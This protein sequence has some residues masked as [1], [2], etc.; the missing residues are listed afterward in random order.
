VY[1][2]VCVIILLT[3]YLVFLPVECPAQ[4]L[5]GAP[6][7]QAILAA[8]NQIQANRDAAIKYS[9]EEA[10]MRNLEAGL[11]KQK[12]KQRQQG[13]GNSLSKLPSRIHPYFSHILGFDDN[14][15]ARKD[16]NKTALTN[17]ITPGFKLNLQQRRHNVAM[18]GHVDALYYNKRKGS[19]V[20]NGQYDIMTNFNIDRFIF[21][22]S[23]SLFSNYISSDKLGV[24][25][26]LVDNYISNDT[27]FVLVSNFNRTGFDLSYRRKFFQYE[28]IKK[29]SDN[30][31]ETIAFANYLRVATKTRFI[32]SYTKGRTR[33]TK[34]SSPDDSRSDAYALGITSVLT[35]KMTASQELSYSKVD[36]KITDDYHDTSLTFRLGYTTAKR[37]NINLIAAR[38]IHKD[39]TES[40]DTIANSLQFGGNRR[41]AISPKLKLSF[42]AGISDVT[43]PK[44]VGFVRKDRQ[45]GLGLGLTY[46]MRQWLDFSFDWS[47]LKNDSNV[48]TNYYK[49]T[50]TF[51]TQAKF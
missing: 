17:S 18:D 6:R 42:S 36:N 46:S 33:Y 14:V 43:Y 24:D 38:S 34:T 15:D 19:N 12:K 39:A 49:N 3:G 37:S 27:T 20:Q 9:M 30:I 47:R 25:D 11:K 51:K 44:R 50:Y 2:T 1:K 29:T 5:F 7:D 22:V 28:P 48:E 26:D 41:L 23:N 32:F 4:Q 35:S 16:R 31:I 45:Y 10:Q 8:F 13:G 21:S 40:E